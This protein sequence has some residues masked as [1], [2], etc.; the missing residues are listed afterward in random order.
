VNRGNP[1]N[2][3]PDSAEPTSDQ[4][5]AGKFE[6]ELLGHPTTP[7]GIAAARNEMRAKETKI[8]RAELREKIF[9]FGD[10]L[11]GAPSD[12]PDKRYFECIA[13][14]VSHMLDDTSGSGRASHLRWGIGELQKAV[15]ILIHERDYSDPNTPYKE[16]LDNE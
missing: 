4:I 6:A 1:E 12:F 16:L 2:P 5:A 7:E 8:R 9:Q 11:V 10:L 3:T 15:A 13:S 14:A